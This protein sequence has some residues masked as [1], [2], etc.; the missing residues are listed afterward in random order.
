MRAFRPFEIEKA[1]IRAA[2][3]QY[4]CGIEVDIEPAVGRNRVFAEPQGNRA[5]CA[6]EPPP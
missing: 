5:L 6:E 1:G 4:D 3:L 2:E